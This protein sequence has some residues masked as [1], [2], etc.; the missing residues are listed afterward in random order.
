MKYLAYGANMDA[1][2][3]RSRCRGAIL[4]GTGTLEGYPRLYQKST[5]TINHEGRPA[6]AMFYHKDEQEPIGQPM[7]HYVEVLDAAYLYYDFDHKILAE[8]LRLSNDY[9]QMKERF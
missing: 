9:F 6:L 7:T 4:L 2:I 8:A 5:V 1:G 3:M